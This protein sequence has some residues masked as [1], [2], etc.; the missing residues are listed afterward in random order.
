[1]PALRFCNA[2]LLPPLLGV[3][4]AWGCG[5]SVQSIYEGNVRF[6]HCYR[7]DIDVNISPTHRLAC[8]QEWL[9]V[10]TYGQVRDRIEYA[11]QRLA[12]LQQGDTSRPSLNLMAGRRPEERGFYLSEPA[13]TSAH[14]PPPP[15][16]K[17]ETPPPPPTASVL[18][19]TPEPA[20]APGEVCGRDCRTDLAS[21]EAECEG[22]GGAAKPKKCKDC[23]ADYKKCMRRC[24]E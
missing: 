4:W 19:A 14:A 8:W 9:R 15:M 22:D 20:P 11:R 7:L 5:P 1:M 18:S 17:A 24:F 16:W 2:L 10:Y 21:C 13:P 3:A 12:A 23:S 6:E